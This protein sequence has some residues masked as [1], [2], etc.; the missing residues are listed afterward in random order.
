[1]K[2]LF[3]LI[4]EKG[5]FKRIADAVNREGLPSFV[6]HNEDAY[7][8]FYIGTTNDIAG[9]IVEMPGIKTSHDPVVDKNYDEMGQ[10]YFDSLADAKEQFK[11]MVKVA[12]EKFRETVPYAEIY[13]DSDADE[14]K[15]LVVFDSKDTGWL[16]SHG[17]KLVKLE[18]RNMG[19][20]N[21]LL[22]G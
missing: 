2:S 7:I 20:I 4:S 17:V 15:V 5:F 9:K 13:D 1:L 10:D 3:D 14:F 6:Q 8:P 19:W 11:G 12:A 18:D 21:S 16:V 22:G